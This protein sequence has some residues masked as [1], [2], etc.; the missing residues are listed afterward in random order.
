[1]GPCAYCHAGTYSRLRQDGASHSKR[2]AQRAPQPFTHQQAAPSHASQEAAWANPAPS[3]TS[4]RGSPPKARAVQGGW[5][6]GHWRTHGAAARQAVPTRPQEEELRPPAPWLTSRQSGRRQGNALPVSNAVLKL[7]E[8]RPLPSEPSLR[9]PRAVLTASVTVTQIPWLD[10]HRA[11][12][13]ATKTELPACPDS[14]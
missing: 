6:R 11:Q 12:Q 2:V 7:T 3:K 13:T 1:M 9:P 8:K 10:S 14:R 5:S 4:P